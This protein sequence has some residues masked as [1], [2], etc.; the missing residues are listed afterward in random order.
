MKGKYQLFQ[1]ML[2]AFLCVCGCGREQTVYLEPAAETEEVRE[3]EQEERKPE[4]AADCYV[5]VCGAVVNPGV[6]RLPEKSRVYEALELAGG[7]TDE[8]G[9]DAVNQA[10]YITDGQ[11]LRIPTAGEAE[12]GGIESGAQ[13]ADDGLLNINRASAE[14]LMSLPGIGQ[15]KAES[16]VRYREKHGGFHSID[17]LMNVEGIK[18]GVFHKIKDE[19]KVN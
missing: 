6:Y 15:S 18:E 4:D 11:M 16:I 8:A 3:T 1:A 2:L 7:V 13:P 12:S 9:I 17:E 19:I 10:E 5:Y 14:E